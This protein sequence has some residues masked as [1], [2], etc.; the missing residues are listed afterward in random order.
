MKR[1]L[2]LILCLTFLCPLVAAEEA[3][4]TLNESEL[5]SFYDGALFFGDSVTSEFARYRSQ[6]RQEE[7]EF[8]KGTTLIY[9]CSISLY[10][11]SRRVLSGELHFKYK[12]KEMTMYQIADR[13]QPKKIFILLGLND[14]V[15]IKIERA[16]GWIGDIVKGMQ[17]FAPEAELYFFSH[18]PVTPNYETTKKR[19]G[20]QQK[21][22]TYNQRLQETCEA[23]D[24][25]FVDIAT[26]MKDEDGYLRA[27][28][29][30]DHICHLNTEGVLVWVRA[31]CDYAQRQ[32][33]AGLWAPESGGENE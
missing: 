27:E 5:L 32:Y 10:A 13:V 23:L 4:A 24:A 18:T 19:P 12:G 20:Y 1:F 15:G 21:L 22:D 26:P 31:L 3:K 7:P 2:A 8:L 6:R 14:P 29:S 9:T 30:G 25:H 33:E 28:Y 17:E 16:M 11:A